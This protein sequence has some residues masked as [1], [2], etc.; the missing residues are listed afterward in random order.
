MSRQSKSG[1]GRNWKHD[2]SK[3]SKL[4]GEYFFTLYY[5]VCILD[6]LIGWRYQREALVFNIK[7][8]C[9]LGDCLPRFLPDSTVISLKNSY[10]NPNKMSQNPDK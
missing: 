4:L 1:L 5:S 3:D 2:H 6:T 8:A 7:K 10:K 9:H